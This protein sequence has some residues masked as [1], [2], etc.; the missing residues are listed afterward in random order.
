MRTR[1]LTLAS[2]VAW[3]LLSAEAALPCMRARPV[4][5]SEMVAGADLI[6]RA[7]AVEYSV[8]PG[9]TITLAPGMTFS[10]PGLRTTGVPDS[11]VRFRVESILKGTFSAAELI[12]PG[13]LSDRDDWNDH[14][15]PY[16]F[17]RPNGRSGSCIANTYRQGAQFLLIM[18]H[19]GTEYTVNWYA[20]GPVN[21]QLRSPDDPWVQWVREQVN[22]SK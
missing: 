14:S 22:A 12:L 9:T 15:P 2:I 19:T 4:S 18:K 7:T 1:I 8:E 6:V 5:A 21:E 13:Y 17:I 3:L 20:L 16:K 11:R 10:G